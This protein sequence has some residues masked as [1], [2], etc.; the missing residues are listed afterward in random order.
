MAKLTN[1]QKNQLVYYKQKGVSY[2]NEVNT[3][4]YLNSLLE[5]IEQPHDRMI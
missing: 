4:T 1:A 3:P 5:T 2:K